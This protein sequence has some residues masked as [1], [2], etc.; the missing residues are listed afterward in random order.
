[1]LALTMTGVLEAVFRIV[2]GHLVDRKWIGPYL[3]YCVGSFI[4]GLGA[5]FCALLPGLTGNCQFVSFR[6]I[7]VTCLR[8]MSISHVR[9]TCLCHVTMSHVRVMCPC[10][11]CIAGENLCL[12]YDRDQYEQQLSTSS[13]LLLSSQLG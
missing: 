6:S 9:V 11:D 7:H 8:H 3:H 4:A 12:E 1:M 10:H 5:L 13:N 2:N